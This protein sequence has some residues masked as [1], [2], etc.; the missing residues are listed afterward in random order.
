VDIGFH[1]FRREEFFRPGWSVSVLRVRHSPAEF[2]PEYH[3]L[4]QRQFW[5]IMYV[6]EG[7]GVMIVNN[8]EYAFAP[9]FAGLIHP[10]DLTTCELK[11]N[12]VLYNIL[13]QTGFIERELESLYRTE[14]FFS[15][16]R[17]DADNRDPIR[18]DVL[19]L[20]DSSRAIYAIVRKMYREYQ[21]D[22]V[23]S[24]ELLRTF[25]LELL[26]SLARQSFSSSLKN[27]G[28][29]AVDYVRSALKKNFA[30]PPPLRELMRATGLSRNRLFALY[31]AE[32]GETMGR[33]LQ[34]HRLNYVLE[35]LKN[36]D[37]TTAKIASLAG[38]PDVSDFYRVF[39]KRTGHSP[40][41]YRV[42]D[43]VEK[44]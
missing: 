15:I 31:K 43:H 16:F 39:R 28:I 27:R 19:H 2:P 3:C 10:S 12:V 18:H 4:N 44:G 1:Q 25:L 13:F 6:S 30:H 33:T 35:L 41:F 14:D 40:G 26:Y 42:R 17:R 11:E 8:R 7:R 5:K 29:F 32:T 20:L 38:F 22:Q 21:S 37:L 9:G 36:T 34:R 24:Q 23:F